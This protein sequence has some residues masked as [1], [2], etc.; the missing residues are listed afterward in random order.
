MEYSYFCCSLLYAPQVEGYVMSA[1][2]GATIEKLHRIC[3][4]CQA[5]EPLSPAYSLCTRLRTTFRDYV[6]ELGVK[7]IEDRRVEVI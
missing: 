2:K 7:V 6:T 4:L 3:G 5:L 1:E